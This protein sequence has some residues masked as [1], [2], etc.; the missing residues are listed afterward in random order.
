[1]LTWKQSVSL[2]VCDIS[3]G[4]V[5]NSEM[6][7]RA[8]CDL[9]KMEKCA[10]PVSSIFVRQGYMYHARAEWEGHHVMHY[11]LYLITTPM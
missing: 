6:A 11:H 3:D 4:Y 10:I 1:M 9:L 5:F 8:L 7:R 2:Y